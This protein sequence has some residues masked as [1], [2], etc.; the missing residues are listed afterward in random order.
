MKKAL[1]VFLIL[2]VAGGLFA[3]ISWSGNA[4]TGVGVGFANEDGNEP[5]IGIMRNKGDNGL[6]LQFVMNGKVATEN[7]GTFTGNIGFRGYYGG[8]F[9]GDGTATM[10]WIED[11]RL[12]W[13]AGGPLNLTLALGNGGPGGTGTMGDFDTNLDAGGGW[14]LAAQI[15]PITGLTIAASAIYGPAQK[16]L[17][18]IVYAFGAKYSAADLLDVAANV[19]FDQTKDDKEKLNFAAGV[20]ILPIVKGLGFTAL[21][22]D[23]QTANGLGSAKS[24][25]RLGQRIGFKVG[26]LGLTLR[27]CEFFWGGTDPNPDFIPMKF[28]LEASYKVSDLVTIGLDGRYIIGNKPAFNWRNAGEI[29]NAGW[30]KDQVGLG[31]SPYVNFNVGGPTITLGYNLQSDMSTNAQKPATGARSLQH[32]VYGQIHVSF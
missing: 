12:T 22:I 14:G 2:A 30:N 29:N 25:F 23:F 1:V 31:V 32:L 26:D 24:D 3:E 19:K 21:A 20:S 13:A 18:E 9:G 4:Q 5:V 28:N 6:Q 16:K 7:Y 17:D 27:A 15:K 11:P 10:A 8:K